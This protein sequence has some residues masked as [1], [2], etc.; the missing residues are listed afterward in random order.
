MIITK[1]KQFNEILKRIENKSVFI[2][3]CSQCATLCHTGGENEA[4]TMKK[5]LEEK[6]IKVTGFTILDPTCHRLNDKRLLKQFKTEI[7]NSSV[8]LSLS[9]GDGLQVI[10]GLYPNKKIISGTNTLFLGVEGKRDEFLK[11]C[12]L[13]GT[14]I[15]DTFYG[16]C[17]IGRCPKNILNGPCGGS[18]NGTC[19]I[20]LDIACVW[21]EIIEKYKNLDKINELKDIID[22]HDWI[23]T[24]QYKLRED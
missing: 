18:F 14:C 7:E 17:P 3:G 9:C 5:N 10:S 1:K 2:I 12:E 8:I 15:S 21:E 19:E 24:F 13:C 23:Q 4:L 22:P 20:S 11:Y 6:N 16:I